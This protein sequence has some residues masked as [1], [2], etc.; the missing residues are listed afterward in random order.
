MGIIVKRDQFI[1]LLP[2]EE[3]KYSCEP[4]K[5]FCLPVLRNAE[6]LY[7]QFKQTP[8]GGN[9]VC[10]GNFEF[11]PTEILTN[12]E[13]LGGT[14]GW[15]LG[16]GWAYGTDN[17]EHTPGSTAN[18]LQGGHTFLT[19]KTY[20]V[21]V[22][23][24]NRTVG[25]IKPFIG[26]GNTAISIQQG[27][28]GTT[29]RY[30][31]MTTDETDFWLA[32]TT[33]FDGTVEMV[34]VKLVSACWEFDNSW[35]LSDG[36]ACHV[37][38]TAGN[39]AQTIILPSVSTYYNANFIVRGITKGFM[40]VLIGGQLI[41]TVNEDG[42]YILYGYS[43]GT[44][45]KITF[46][47]SSD[48]DGCVTDVSAFLLQEEFSLELI[49][50][51][52]NVVLGISYD[53]FIDLNDVTLRIS[54]VIDPGCYRVRLNSSCEDFDQIQ[55]NTDP[56]FD[57]P[58][59][60]QISGW[61]G[62]DPA[63]ISGG[64]LFFKSFSGSAS[65]LAEQQFLWDNIIYACFEITIV[66]GDFAQVS[67]SPVNSDVIFF[68]PGAND[69]AGTIVVA[70]LIAPLG[71]S[72]GDTYTKNVCVP[73]YNTVNNEYYN[74]FGLY[75]ST[76]DGNDGDKFKVVSATIK[77]TSFIR[78]ADVFESNCLSVMEDLGNSRY[79]EGYSNSRNSLGFN[80]L[81]NF[82]L[83]ARLPMSFLNPHRP[84][85]SDTYLYSTGSKYKQYAQVD[86]LW[87]LAIEAVDENTHD[88]IAVITQCDNFKIGSDPN[89]TIEYFAEIKDYQ[90]EWG[91]KSANDVAEVKIEVG[92]KT[93]TIFNYKK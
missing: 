14:T 35:I 26:A 84:I 89:N 39:I 32:P 91:E 5:E 65:V 58:S 19:G 67:G 57:S 36:S 4:T 81:N 29:T 47:A 49:D 1:N 27:T 56:E 44:D 68:Y 92:R 42:D 17:V 66:M 70:S 7:L 55:V 72:A 3:K 62:A 30:I 87:D 24:S 10:D 50:L 6:S 53:T 38:G 76:N 13:F 2:I 51:F 78:S 45:D 28:G 69:L 16:A 48:F 75:F 22:T 40:D 74:K 52:G 23:F 31:T 80:F 33:D 41:G 15:T 59:D 82:R 71:F 21:T 63:G 90:P 61:Q 86:K 88:A 8:C 12:T 9:L 64:E 25:G 34:S 37:P 85:K 11:S 83:A 60:W 73:I 43:L 79:I 46:S 18:L 20:L 54:S 77:I 93:G